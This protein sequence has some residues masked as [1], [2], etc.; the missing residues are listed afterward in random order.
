[1]KFSISKNKKLSPEAKKGLLP[2]KEFLTQGKQRFLAAFD[3]SPMAVHGAS[4][5]RAGRPAPQRSGWAMFFRVGASALAAIAVAFGVSAYAATAANVAPTNPLYPL[6]RLV[7]NVQLAVAPPQAKAQLQAT[8]AVRR[9]NEIDALQVEHPTST[10]IPQ[11]TTD[12]DTEISSSLAEAN[13]PASSSNPNAANINAGAEG[14][15][16]VF[17]GAFVK[18]TSSVLFGHLES[19]LVLHPNILNQFNE[20]CGSESRHGEGAAGSGATASTTVNSVEPN[21]G[22]R[23]HGHQYGGSG[24]SAAGVSGGI[25]TGAVVAVPSVSIPSVGVAASATVNI[26]GT[27]SATTQGTSSVSAPTSFSSGSSGGADLGDDG[28]G[29]FG[30]GVGAAAG[31]GGNV[32]ESAPPLPVSAPSLGGIL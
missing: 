8:F 10:L 21:G 15:V 19:G 23:G 18:S 3:A 7:E 31:A 29:G 25:D 2:R 14:A 20:Q 16:S 4:A 28:G 13:Q 17:C 26:V 32:H 5:P 24:H 9:A 11:L 30:S 6:K 22:S 27:S 1:M 12:L